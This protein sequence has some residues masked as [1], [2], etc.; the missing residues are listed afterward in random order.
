MKKFYKWVP[1]YF[2]NL[3][4]SRKSAKKNP[5]STSYKGE[6]LMGLEEGNITA[7]GFLCS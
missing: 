3:P 2:F 7:A 6:M 5:S 1:F 4:I